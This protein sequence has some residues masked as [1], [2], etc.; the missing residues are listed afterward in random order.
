LVL[1]GIFLNK[2]Q[3]NQTKTRPYDRKETTKKAH[4]I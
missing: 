3:I 4:L 2:K 1:C